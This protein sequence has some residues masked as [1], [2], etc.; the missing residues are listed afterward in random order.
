MKKKNKLLE[1][2]EQADQMLRMSR[3]NSAPPRRALRTADAARYLGISPSLLRKMR[4]RGPEDPADPG[5]KF[6]KLSPQLIVYDIAALDAWL[7]S[8]AAGGAPKKS[9]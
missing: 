5:P 7:D 1:S 9:V 2:V 4:M 6:I 3:R 8:H